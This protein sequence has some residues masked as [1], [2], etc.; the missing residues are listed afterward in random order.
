MATYETRILFTGLSSSDDVITKGFLV[1]LRSWFFKVK[2]KLDINYLFLVA[3]NDYRTQSSQIHSVTFVQCNV[4]NPTCPYSAEHFGVH[5]THWSLVT[6]PFLMQ[7]LK[8]EGLCSYSQTSYTSCTHV[9]DIISLERH[10]NVY[11][12]P[13]LHIMI[14]HTSLEHRRWPSYVISIEILAV[15][16][17]W[18]C[19]WTF[20][21]I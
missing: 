16:V 21:K 8:I 2:T 3:C 5:C 15:C 1:C 19:C 20:L 13:T 14:C 12:V 6:N 18:V 4:I 7:I 11:S 9:W 10:G 17:Y